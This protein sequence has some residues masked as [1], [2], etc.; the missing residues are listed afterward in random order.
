MSINVSV[1][2]KTKS[3]KNGINDSYYMQKLNGY[4]LAAHCIHGKK[5]SK[6]FDYQN[7]LDYIDKKINTQI[8][9][10]VSSN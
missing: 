2:H 8:F 9:K 6:L 1:L 5:R 7:F 4:S 10:S 3:G